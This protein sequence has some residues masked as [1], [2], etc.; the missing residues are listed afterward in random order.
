VACTQEAPLFAE[1]LGDAETPLSHTNIRETAGWSAQAAAATAKTAALLAEAALD[2]KPT[3]TVS[4][5]SEGVT[6][7]LGRDETALSAARQ[8]SQRLNVTVLLEPDAVATPPA[9]NDV[10][11]FAGRVHRA[12]GQ[13]GGFELDIDGF[14][15]ALPSS[16]DR[17]VF[18][19]A[20][21]GAESKCDIIIDLRGGQPLFRRRDG[22]L[23][24]D[25]G[26]EVQVQRTLF[27]AIELVG[28]FEKPR[29]VRVNPD[30]CAHSRNSK[31]G[32]T[33]CLDA[34]PSGAIR[35]AGDAVAVDPL[36]CSG[37]GSCSSVCPTGAITYDLPGGDGIFLRLR[38]LLE[39]YRRAGGRR[40]V[41]LAHDTR[42]GSEVIAAMARHGRGLPANVIP[43]AVNEVTQIGF[44]GLAAALAYG[45]T[46]V[47]LLAGPALRGET[48]GLERAVE[49]A[50]AVAAGLGYGA[51]RVALDWVEDPSVFEATLYALDAA[52]AGAAAEFHPAGGRR[53]VQTLALR[54]L[55]AH[56]P[57]PVD[58]LPLPDGA[59]FGAVLVDTVKCTLC[60]SCVGA[61]PT[62]ALG[63]NPDKPQLNFAE[64]ACVQCGL[65]RTTCPENAIALAP[66]LDFTAAAGERKVLKEEEPFH[67]VKCGKPFGTH[68]AID[69][70]LQKL[71]G[72]SMFAEPGR[73]ELL[74]M[75]ADCRV[76]AQF[77]MQNPL[78]ARPRPMPRTTDD[79][80]RERDAEPNPTRH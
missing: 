56:A 75:C 36:A 64:S 2:L 48:A 12:R 24:A 76:V 34:C 13:L 1:M 22:Y 10:P 53:A 5:N 30:I 54:H 51:G 43:F 26:S 68:S 42:F 74:K 33:R 57:T 31:T 18:D 79:Y 70:M 17:L 21:D 59:P 20:R 14:A 49:L 58:M 77:D 60:L 25:P 63:D 61:C 27:E 50:D 72:H 65:C 37:H 40:P 46:Q 80:L 15:A 11:V 66:R 62:R 9:V 55:H 6:L 7:I 71:T 45:A 32:C 52:E 47:R 28:E 41:I 3:P 69:K 73:L 67:C 16:R 39:A 78:G 8:L 19:A 38:T 29:Y 4:L 35:P 23:R 44:D